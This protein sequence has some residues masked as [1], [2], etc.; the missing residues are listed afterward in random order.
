MEVVSRVV[1][2]PCIQ[3]ITVTEAFF[4]QW[5]TEMQNSKILGIEISKW[6][7]HFTSIILWG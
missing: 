6:L 2:T 4:Y 7:L 1:M 3:T 5:L